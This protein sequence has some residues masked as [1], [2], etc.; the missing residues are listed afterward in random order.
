[1][2]C[3]LGAASHSVE[4]LRSDDDAACFIDAALRVES[5]AGNLFN[6]LVIGLKYLVVRAIEVNA[7][8][9]IS[10]RL[11]ADPAKHQSSHLVHH[12]E[13]DAAMGRDPVVIIQRFERH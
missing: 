5:I 11:V 13:L 9:M 4:R 7:V 3:E 10:Q 12:P 6:K 8:G 1:M 2:L